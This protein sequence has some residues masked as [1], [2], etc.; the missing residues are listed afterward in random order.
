MTMRE[1]LTEIKQELDAL[2]V[3]FEL[4]ERRFEREREITLWRARQLGVLNA[5]HLAELRRE[6]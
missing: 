2:K 3:K 4:L 6:K 1:R 5:N